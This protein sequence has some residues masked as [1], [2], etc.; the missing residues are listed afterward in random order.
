[1]TNKQRIISFDFETSGLQ[2]SSLQPLSLGGCALDPRTLEEI[3]H[4]YSLIRPS[5]PD[6]LDEGSM[7]VNRLDRDQLAKAPG[8]DAVTRA[9]AAWA[10]S[11]AGKGVTGKPIACGKNIIRF[12]L[13][14]LSRL[15]REQKIAGKAGNQKVFSERPILDLEELAWLWFED[16]DEL[17]NYSM[18]AMREFFGLE[19]EN[20]H[21]ALTDC[22]QAAELLR[23]FLKLH[24][25]IRSMKTPSG[26]PFVKWRRDAVP[27]E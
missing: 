1:M 12:D 3:D 6:N 4:F 13:P 24:R 23:R 21:H 14:I 22:R 25:G 19:T 8:A 11:H 15:C 16:S 17:P 2:T 7:R 9:F 10:K 18:D 27:A 26:A 5:D 20:A